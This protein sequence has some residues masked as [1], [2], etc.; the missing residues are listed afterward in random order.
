MKTS[1]GGVA[2]WYDKVVND[3]DSYQS[4]VILP[5]VMRLMAPKKGDRILDLAC[6]QG[7]FSHAMAS[8]GA[9]VTGVDVAPELIDIAR[10][11]A[12]HN[13]E[14]YVLSADN[15]R[16]FKDKS[17]DSAVCVL[18]IQNIEKMGHAFKEASRVLRDKSRF[19]V[20]LNHPAFRIPGKTA[21]G[22]DERA[23]VQYRRVDEYVSESR[24]AIDM[25][26]GHFGGHARAEVTY[27]FHRPLQAYSKSLANAGFAILRIEEWMSHKESEKGPRKQ[28]EDKARREIPMFMCLECVKL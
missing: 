14:F 7:F 23:G 16:P 2:S 9:H 12:M 15:L 20:V 21:W 6:G 26:P 4:Q 17:F 28:A 18:A 19:V 1:W 5:N 13:Q 8:A 11:H 24:A 3:G 25:H 22:F 27:S 10:T